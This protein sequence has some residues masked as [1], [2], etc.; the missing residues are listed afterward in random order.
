MNWRYRKP[1]PWICLSNRGMMEG[2]LFRDSELRRNNLIF[3]QALRGPWAWILFVTVVVFVVALGF[4]SASASAPQPLLAASE[5]DIDCPSEVELEVVALLN[6]ERAN[7]SLPP[8]SIDMRLMEAARRHNN[9]MA[10][11]DFFSHTG[12]DGSSPFDRITDA[13]YPYRSAGE[14]IAAGYQT[15]TAAVQAWMNSSGHRANILNSSYEHIGVAYVFDS[16]ASYGHYWTTDFGSSSDAGQLPPAYCSSPVDPTPTPTPVL[17][18]TFVDVPFNHPYYDEIEL[19][20]NEGYTSGC[21]TDPLMFCPERTMN[22]AESAVFVERGI[23]GS[24]YDPQDPTQVLFA[25]VAIE[26]WY[27]DWVHGLWDDGYTAGCNTDPLAYCPD[28]AHTRAEGCVFYLRMMYGADYVPPAPVGYFGDVDSGKWYADWVDACWEAGIGEPCET[29]PERL[30]CP[31][32]PLTRAVAAY[33]MVQ[34][35]ELPTTP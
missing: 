28:Q 26:A 23:H 11:N 2:M 18:P 17:T 21:S 33:M 24:E 1:V 4:N 12:S 5:Q 20:Y 10:I 32:D 8:L 31:D 14:N 16:T 22:R 7:E 30:F 19:L 25:D 3:I 9:D 15:A 27:S 29:A 34:A 35:K 13:G 6:Q